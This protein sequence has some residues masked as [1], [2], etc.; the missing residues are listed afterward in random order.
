[1]TTDP[2]RPPTWYTNPTPVV[3]VT[4]AP[5]LTELRAC[6]AS[7]AATTVPT[8]LILVSNGIDISDFDDHG[9]TTIQL[10]E[11][12]GYGHAA[13]VGIATAIRSG[14]DRV[15]L[16][17]DDLTV[18]P[19]WLKSLH[20]ALD[21]AD[22]VGAVQPK[23]LIRGSDPELV[24]SCGVTLLRNASGID[25]DFGLPNDPTDTEARPIEIFSGGCVLFRRDFI[26]STGGFDESFFL[27]YEDVDLAIRGADHGWSYMC[28]PRSVVHHTVGG[29]HLSSGIRHQH[30]EQSRLRTATRVG[31]LPCIARAYG[32]AAIRTIRY[33]RSELR[34]IAG[35]LR[36]LRNDRR[37]RMSRRITPH[38]P[39]KQVG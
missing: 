29:T 35:A 5:A 8:H 21:R 30:R 4:H 24:N 2:E 13:N 6:L 18:T 27:Y 17:N 15:A 36:F 16:I 38:P 3:V 33:P 12:R 32:R 22:D 34:A 14:H 28:V 19:E 20:K 11:N 26:M 10:S 37:F 31:S 7:V 9:V 25:T 1:M 23:L 39:R